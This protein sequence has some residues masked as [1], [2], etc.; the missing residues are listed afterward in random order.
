MGTYQGQQPPE[1][2][3]QATDPLRRE[4]G[5][6]L[7]DGQGRHVPDEQ[8]HRQPP[9]PR[10]NRVTTRLLSRG[11]HPGTLAHERRFLLGVY[12]GARAYISLQAQNGWTAAAGPIGTS[13]TCGSFPLLPIGRHCLRLGA[14][15]F[16]RDPI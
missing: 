16:T 13:G 1:S 4:D 8:A 9:I 14:S 10:R 2:G 12:G 6:D 11:C 5:G 15:H 7:Q 3:K